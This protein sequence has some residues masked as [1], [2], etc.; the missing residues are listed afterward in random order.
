MTKDDL[1]TLDLRRGDVTR[2]EWLRRAITRAAMPV[3]VEPV[4]A[5][6]A[7]TVSATPA[8]THSQVVPG[9]RTVASRITDVDDVIK[10]NDKHN[11]TRCSGGNIWR[12]GNGTLE[13][14]DGRAT[15]ACECGCG[16]RRYV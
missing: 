10:T 14:V 4:F 8:P 16:E 3:A 11:P 9:F 7:V 1:D 2:S 6:P 12:R 13:R 5:D 15:Y